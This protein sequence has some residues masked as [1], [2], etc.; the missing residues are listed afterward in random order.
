MRVNRVGST[1]GDNLGPEK[2]SESAARRA[3]QQH[4]HKQ[5][6]LTCEALGA[7]MLSQRQPHSEPNHQ[8]NQNLALE[9]EITCHSARQTLTVASQVADAQLSNLFRRLLINCVASI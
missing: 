1:L 9:D 7:C 3:T 2:L 8:I 6:F 5:V 4:K